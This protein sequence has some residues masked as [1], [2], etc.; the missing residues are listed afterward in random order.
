VLLRETDRELTRHFL[1]GLNELA[2]AQR[3]ILFFDTYEKTAAYL[4]RWLRDVVAGKFG[5]VSGR[6]LIVMAGRYPP[7]Q[8]WTAYKKAIRQVDLREFTEAEAREYVV[9]AG[10]TDEAQIEELIRLSERLPVL[11]A[12]LTSAPGHVSTDVSESAVERFLQ[13][14]TE[15]Q[16]EAALV[17]SVPRYFNEDVLADI[18][19]ADEVK[20]AF[21]WLSRAHFVKGSAHGWV[22]HEVVRSLMV[23]YFR[24]RSAQRCRALHAKLAAYYESQAQHLNLGAGK[25]YP[26]QRWRR[27]KNEYLY[28]ALAQNPPERVEELFSYL[29]GSF[30]RQTGKLISDE[31]AQ[32]IVECRIIL[33]QVNEESEE[34]TIGLWGSQLKQLRA[35]EDA[36]APSAEG[37]QTVIEIFGSM[38]NL[39]RLGKIERSIAFSVCAETHL[40]AESELK[41]ERAITDFTKAIELQP[42]NGDYYYRRGWSH[43][44]AQDYPAALA[45]FSKAIEL[46][47]DTGDNYYWRGLTHLEA[48]DYPAALAD[49]SKAIELQPDNGYNYHGRGLTHREAQD[50]PAALADLSKAIELQPE[51]AHNYA[52][53][54]RTHL[55]LD[56][57]DQA[58]PDFSKVRELL[59]EKGKPAYVVAGG[60]SKAGQELDACAWLRLAFERDRSLV[61]AAQIEV[62]FA[63]IRETEAFKALVE[64]FRGEDS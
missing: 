39:E 26:H 38:T 32:A 20:E 49:Y 33:D 51:D 41:F 14:A 50:Y 24:L 1:T 46:Q 43:L 36:S 8:A 28:H 29:L 9:N 25:Q 5:Q 64:E 11:L 35:I 48:Q 13:G 59:N 52:W 17:A 40:L 37:V 55:E 42:E 34:A 63:A 2:K 58:Q 53:R 30:R 15:E 6:V 21:E 27:Y 10:V 3:V 16:R 44:E 7:G 23:R 4:D 56:D 31:L 62:E 22:Y 19:G 61:E 60:Y 54:G 47:P 18:L 12:L 57:H 45:D